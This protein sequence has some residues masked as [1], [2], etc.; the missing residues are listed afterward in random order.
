MR[1]FMEAL[2]TEPGGIRSSQPFPSKSCLRVQCYVLAEARE[3]QPWVVSQL[4]LP[5]GIF[6][7]PGQLELMPSS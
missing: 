4:S 1:E 3:G 5:V 2:L 7:T 6:Q